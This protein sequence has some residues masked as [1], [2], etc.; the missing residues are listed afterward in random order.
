MVKDTLAWLVYNFD[1]CG[2]Q[3][4]KGKSRK[5]IGLKGAPDLAESEKGENIDLLNH[6]LG[7]VFDLL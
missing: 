1:K 3:P 4:G 7:R 6:G 2:F 5:V